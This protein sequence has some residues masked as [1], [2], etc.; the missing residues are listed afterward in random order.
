MSHPIVSL[1]VRRGLIATFVWTVLL[2]STRAPLANAV[3]PEDAEHLIVCPAALA[4]VFQSLA[5]H[6]TREGTPSAVVTLEDVLVSATGRDDAE[7]LRNHLVQLN[8][9]GRLRYVLL[10]G[11]AGVVPVRM[12]HSTFYPSGGATDLSSDLYFAAMDGDWDG[13]GDGIFAEAFVSSADPGDDADLAPELAVGRAPV[14]TIAQAQR[15]VDGVLGYDNA[16]QSP[17]YGSALL[18]AEVLFPADWSGGSFQLDG[19]TY[20]ESVRAGLLTHPTPAV[21][22]RLYENTGA[23]PGSNPLNLAN[24]LAE[25]ESGAHGT[26]FYVG[27]G[28]LQSFTLGADVLGL[29][30]IDA[31]VNAPRYNV[32]LALS[33]DAAKFT[34]DCILEHMVTAPNGG[35]AAAIG[36]SNVVFQTTAS[37]YSEAFY[38]A[39]AA[40]SAVRVGDAMKSTLLLHSGDTF[41]EAPSRWTSLS[42]V[43]LGDP[44]MPFRSESEPV[45]TKRASVGGLKGRFH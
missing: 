6:R 12:A 37:R 25:L 15:F 43:L 14:S 16:T 32:I 20:A 26:M 2:V 27:G 23:Y 4:S 31:L 29:A 7:T 45:P 39:L 10:G 1:A 35:S 13:D 41:F 42:M 17:H 21:S 33:G 3:Q 34:A 36:F 38:N 11:D 8:S 18:M 24:T 22:L 19:A 5:D 9:L 44:A 30:D 40:T 28:D